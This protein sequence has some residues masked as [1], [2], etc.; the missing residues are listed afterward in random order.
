MV[1]NQSS[2]HPLK[3]PD[4][5]ISPVPIPRAPVKHMV[6]YS[7]PQEDLK[8]RHYM[9]SDFTFHFYLFEVYSEWVHT[10]DIIHKSYIDQKP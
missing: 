4:Y 3:W 10:E 1:L 8:K 7:H 9:K 2:L 5:S 6:S